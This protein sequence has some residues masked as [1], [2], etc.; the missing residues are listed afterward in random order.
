M[1]FF[2]FLKI[3]F[4]LL[5]FLWIY[6]LNNL[7]FFIIFNEGLFGFFLFLLI[8]DNKVFLLDFDKMSLNFLLLFLLLLIR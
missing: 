5:V 7:K 8:K 2:N 3:V 1:S 4:S 6:S